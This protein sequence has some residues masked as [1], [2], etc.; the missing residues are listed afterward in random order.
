VHLFVPEFCLGTMF[1]WRNWRWLALGLLG[2][3]LFTTG[4]SAAEPERKVVSKVQPAYPELAKQIN[5]YGTVKVEVVIAPNGAVKTMR[6]LGGHPLLIKAATE[7]LRKWRYEPG[8]E[9][10]TIVEFRFH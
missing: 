2:A 9:T 6:P 3:A 1:E 5:V 10:T 4:A 7:A 8:P